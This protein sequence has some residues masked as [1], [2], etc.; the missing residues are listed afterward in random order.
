M[1]QMLAVARGDHG[2]R[3]AERRPAELAAAVVPQV[4]EGEVEQAVEQHPVAGDADDARRLLDRAA[5]FRV[6]QRVRRLG[7]AG[8]DGDE[9]AV[10]GLG[11]HLG[12][13]A[14]GLAGAELAAGE[15]DVLEAA[16]VR[17]VL[18]DQPH[19]GGVHPG[20]RP[21]RR[22][23]GTAA[24]STVR[25]K[26]GFRTARC[27]ACT[28]DRPSRRR[29]S[30][31]GGRSCRGHRRDNRAGWPRVRGRRRRGWGRW[32]G[33]APSRRSRRSSGR[34]ASPSRG[35]CA[36]VGGASVDVGGAGGGGSSPVHPDSRTRAAQPAAP[37]NTG[38]FRVFPRS[39]W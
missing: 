9:Q 15:R 21:T 24:G 31:P 19:A 10:R 36:T 1:A 32:W 20:R 16:A 34:P 18:P 37:R 23:R 17:G 14:G 4:D 33:A 29:A 3:D 12:A 27:C 13:A 8:V 38:P 30:R 35:V 7:G 28:A 22:R 39:P 5:G 26:R 6:D 11:V 25:C 2:G